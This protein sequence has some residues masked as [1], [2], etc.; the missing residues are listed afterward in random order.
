[1]SE[2]CP[3]PPRTDV[4]LTEAIQNTSQPSSTR[5]GCHTISIL[6]T[7]PGLLK[8]GASA[9]RLAQRFIRRRRKALSPFKKQQYEIP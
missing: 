2:T 9:H 6:A 5:P 3:A 4:C 8:T 1:G 7:T